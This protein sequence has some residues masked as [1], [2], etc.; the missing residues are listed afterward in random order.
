MLGISFQAFPSGS[1]EK[2]CGC[3]ALKELSHILGCT[4]D[5]VL[6]GGGNKEASSPVE[7]SGWGFA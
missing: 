7:T 2:P 3:V 5:G 4:I 1:G 6:T